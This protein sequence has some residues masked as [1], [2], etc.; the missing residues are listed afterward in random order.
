[1][2]I[3][4]SGKLNSTSWIIDARWY[5]APLAFFL[6]MVAGKDAFAPEL[7][8]KPLLF[9]LFMAIVFNLVFY[10]SM[11]NLRLTRIFSQ[12]IT[13][14]NVSQVA[15]DLLFFFVI[16]M[17]TG[18]GVESIAHAFY[19]IPIVVSMILFGYRGAILVAICSGMFIFLSVFI[20]Y[21]FIL[22]TLRFVETLRFKNQRVRCS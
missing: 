9:L 17:I 13:F 3:E 8:Y 1:M 2:S 12:H 21:G 22:P 4:L 14:L 7:S 20:Q 16:I 6:G 19:F 18:G 11:R 10:F 5:Y 15:F